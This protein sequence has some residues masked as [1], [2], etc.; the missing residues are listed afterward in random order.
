MH[1]DIDEALYQSVQQDDQ[2]VKIT[3]TIPVG[4][5]RPTVGGVVAC[6][7]PEMVSIFVSLFHF[8]NVQGLGLKD[9]SAFSKGV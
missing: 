4:K 6:G 1:H 3:R 8:L 9:G 5:F 2:D 7:L